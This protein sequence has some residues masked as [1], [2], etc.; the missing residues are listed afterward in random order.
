MN[1]VWRP[2]DSLLDRNAK[3]EVRAA[4]RVTD[5]LRKRGIRAT[6]RITTSRDPGIAAATADLKR[7]GMPAGVQQWQLPLAQPLEN[8]AVFI[9]RMK[10]GVA[11]PEHAHSVWVF[12]IV[13]QGSVKYGRKTLKPG[14]WMLVPPGQVYSISAGPTGCT[15]LYG[16]C[17]VKPPL[18]PPTPP[19]P[20]RGG[21]SRSGGVGQ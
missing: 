21:Q 20:K 13:I 19:G 11:V 17:V 4:R 6:N 8:L 14:E 1:S 16:H 12:R 18:P 9:S 5:V 3:G 15:V 7:T 2:D 10:P